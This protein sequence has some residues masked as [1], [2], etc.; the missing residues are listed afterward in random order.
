MNTTSTNSLPR[1]Q[2]FILAGGQGE[3]L[4]PLTAFRPKPAIWFGGGA[5]IIDFTLSNCLKS[6]VGRV[7]VLTQYCHDELHDHIRQ[8]WSESWN[9]PGCGSRRLI[10]LPPSSG[11]RY[12]GTADAVFHNLPVIESEL[13]EYVLVL[14][15]DHVYE[16]DYRELLA[17]HVERGADVT[18][19]TVEHPVRGAA[20][21][22]VVEVDAQ[23]RVTGF[24]EKPPHPRGLPM[25]PDVALV[26]MGIYAFRS[27]VLVRALVENCEHGSSFDFGHH[28]IPR[29]IE[30]ARVHAFDFRDDV[31]DSPRYWRDIGTID[32]Y[33]EANM[34]LVSGKATFQTAL[35]SRPCAS[36]S[37][38]A[39]LR[40]SVISPG[41]RVEEDASI[42][43]SVLMPGVQVGQGA[44]LRRTIVAEGVQIPPR[45][46]AGW[47]I[48][49][50]RK[51]HTVS[52]NGVVVIS[53][54]PRTA[55]RLVVAF[56]SGRNLQAA[57]SIA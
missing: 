21:F 25:R 35:A 54:T 41:V 57:Q 32:S 23:F 26:S 10:C 17:Q 56:H 50:D 24:Q 2:A 20:H 33:Y 12:R 34:D 19:G 39:R 40:H 11:K 53:E 9:Q 31:Q 4:L 16:M 28:V 15:G 46:A 42:N 45:F 37:G 55:R 47:D 52:P 8:T 14:S 38:G 29:L 5:R 27:D 49:D 3:R 36:I 18:I 51:H 7:A 30:R 1:T 13:P 44:Q 43:E 6:R 48:D 22:G